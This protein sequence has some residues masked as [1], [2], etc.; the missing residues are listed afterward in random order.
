MTMKWAFVLAAFLA[1]IAAYGCGV[2]Q[3]SVT[4]PVAEAPARPLPFKGRLVDGDSGGLPPAVAMSLSNNSAVT[5]SYRE[6]LTH[7]EYHIPLIVSALDPVTYVGSPLGDYGVTAFASLS[8]TDGD[9]VL[10]DYTAKAHVSK[11]YNLYAEPTHKE[12]E[13]AARAAVRQRIDQKLYQDADR[14]ARAVAN[15][16]KSATTS[17]LGK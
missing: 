2:Q 9:Q 3:P 6:E 7:D 8:I 16:G 14:L 4:P 1:A 5:F 10:G 11:S 13:E 17:P 12:L 15:S